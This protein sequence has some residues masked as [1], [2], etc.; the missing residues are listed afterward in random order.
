MK[1]VGNHY[2]FF[3]TTCRTD[4]QKHSTPELIVIRNKI[5]NYIQS[6]TKVLTTYLAY[7]TNK[8][9]TVGEKD[10]NNE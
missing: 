8:R 2:H 1:A 7:T 10:N 6:V 3:I 4:V 5:K 9:A